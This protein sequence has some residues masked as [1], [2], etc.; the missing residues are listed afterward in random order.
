MRFRRLQTIWNLRS[1]SA[2]R[3]N[4]SSCVL[5]TVVDAATEV[6]TEAASE[7]AEDI[8]CVDAARVSALEGGDNSEMKLTRGGNWHPS[9]FT[10]HKPKK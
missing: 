5:E 10:F 3:I 7:H 8:E 4:C 1:C 6:A 2:A 9:E